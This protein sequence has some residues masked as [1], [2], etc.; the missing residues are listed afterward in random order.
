VLFGIGSSPTS[1]NGV[2]A[3]VES[4]TSDRIVAITP[5]ARGFGQNLVNQVVSVVVRNLNTGFTTLAP[6]I[7]KYGTNVLITGMGPGAGPY[8]GG[9]RVTIFG[10]G[11]DDPVAVSLGGVGQ[12]VLSVSGTEIVFR[13]VGTVVSTCPASGVVTVTGVGVTNLETGDGATAQLGFNYIVP[14]PQIFGIAPTAGSPG[15]TATVSGQSFATNIQVLF[16]DPTNGSS[17]PIVSSTASSITLRVPQAPAGFAFNTEPCD[18][19]GDGI[20]G[21]TRL[22]P[23]AISVTV[24][25]LDG[26]GCFVTLPNAFLLN[27]PNTTCTGDTS[28][29][30]PTTPQCNDG[31]DNDGDGRVD[32][33]AAPNNDPGCASLEDN[34]EAG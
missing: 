25:N 8:T 16:G 20:P 5:A 1:F 12:E 26:T 24:R 28:Q 29:P 4:V 19:N 21:G 9:T 13:T 33:G 2:E 14:R 15:N 10:Q 18:G 30:P 27:P 7:F 6:Q 32:F 22:T 17:A 34:S 23:T 3:T 31:I 11:F